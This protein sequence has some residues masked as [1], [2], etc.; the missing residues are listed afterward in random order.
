LPEVASR[1]AVANF[2]LRL[3]VFGHSFSRPPWTVIV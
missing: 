2:Q 3:A 1:S